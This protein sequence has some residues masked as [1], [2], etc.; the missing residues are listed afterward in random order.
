M[1]NQPGNEGRERI[2]RISQR[3]LGAQPGRGIPNF[4]LHSSGK[5][6]VFWP[7]IPSKVARKANCLVP[8]RKKNELSEHRAQFVLYGAKVQGNMK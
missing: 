1:Y 6:P 3:E 8:K 4:H 5:N 7:Y 2:W